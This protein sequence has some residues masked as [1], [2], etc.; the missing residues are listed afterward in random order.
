[1]VGDASHQIVFVWL[2]LSISHSPAVLAAVLVATSVT[3]AALLLLG[4]AVSDQV[5][6]RTVMFYSHWYAVS[7]WRS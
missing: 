6:A 3:R 1:M 7:R 4:G 5:S 2:V